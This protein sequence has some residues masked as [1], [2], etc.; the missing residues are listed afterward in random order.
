MES[1][2]PFALP[3]NGRGYLLLKADRFVVPL[4]AR[5]QADIV[6][7]GRRQPLAHPPI[8]RHPGLEL[9]RPPAVG[10]AIRELT[11]RA[12]PVG[13]AQSG[14]YV[15]KDRNPLEIGDR[16]K[17]N[18]RRVFKRRQ[19]TPK[20]GVLAIHRQG[21]PRID[22]VAIEDIAHGLAFQCRFN[23]QTC[24][25][26]SVA[27]HSL[28]VADLV[29]ESHRLAALLH[30]AAEAYLG[31][32]VK[33][34]KVLM[35]EF[36]GIE[37]KVTALIGP[38]GCGKSTFLRCFNRMHDLYAGHRYDGAIQLHPDEVDILQSPQRLGGIGNGDAPPLGLG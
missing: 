4:L 16:A 18:I 12:D 20:A 37:D 33:P 26:Y 29:P 6:E 5:L 24:D 35:P 15:L 17:L 28:I 30:D 31:D 32:M 8:Q 2:A 27:Q 14:S 34:L 10:F 13:A 22:K 1:S 36:S 23:G 38:S 11:E 19:L 7:V 3:D 9:Q 21:Q 25:F